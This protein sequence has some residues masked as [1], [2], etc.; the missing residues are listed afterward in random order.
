MKRHACMFMVIALLAACTSEPSRNA[1]S[2]PTPEPER[3]NVLVVVTDDMRVDGLQAMPFTV[4]WLVGGGRF[5]RN[6]YSTTPLCCPSRASIFTGLYAHNHGVLKNRDSHDLDTGTTIQAYLRSQADYRTAL[7]GKYL[8]SWNVSE[9]PPHFDK[10]AS[11]SGRYYG[12]PFNVN[13]RTTPT[14]DYSTYHIGARALQFLRRFERADD[15]PWFLYVATPAP[16]TPFTIPS[17]YRGAD[18]PLIGRRLLDLTDPVPRERN[19]S[20]KPD[21]QG[22]TFALERP[23]KLQRKQW[24]MLLPVD[25]IMR[26]FRRALKRLG[27]EEDTVVVFTSDQGLLQGEHGLFAKRL[28]YTESI[29]VPLLVRWP[30]HIEQGSDDRL[31]ANVDIAPMIAELAGADPEPP[32]DGAS[33]LGAEARTELFIEQ[34]DNWRVGLPDWRSLRAHGYQYIEY[35]TRAGDLME[36][37]YYDLEA[38]PWQFRNLFGDRDPANDPDVEALSALIDAYSS[39]G[40]DE[41]LDPR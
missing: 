28:P 31:V 7:A 1:E 24:R 35:Y 6:A 2:T 18:V 21:Y 16:H 3:P 39:C 19:L 33:L 15:Q 32:M 11:Y 12:K 4:Q 5:Y 37:E 9:D 26:K 22:R 17:Q 36:R 30:G 25:D 13:G 23:R 14:D 40:G 20:D 41:C 34:L 29:Q 27:E 38:D 10:W 8:N